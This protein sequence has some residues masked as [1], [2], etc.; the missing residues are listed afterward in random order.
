MS[1]KAAKSSALHFALHIDAAPAAPMGLSDG[2]DDE[3]GLN[4]LGLRGHES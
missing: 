2:Q 4:L 3:L 1:R